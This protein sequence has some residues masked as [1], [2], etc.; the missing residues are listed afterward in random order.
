MSQ[1]R[2]LATRRFL[3]LFATQALGAFNDN[4]FRNALA[5]LITYDLAAG[6]GIDATLVITLAAGLFIVPF[7]LFS[8]IAGALADKYDKA[9]LSRRFKL[10]EIVLMVLAAIGFTIESITWQL[11]VLFLMGTQSAFFGPI[12]YGILPQHL[13]RR[14]LVGA[15]ALVEMGTFLAILTGLMFGGLM[16]QLAWG[17][18]IVSASVIAIAALGYLAARA[19]PAAPPAAPGLKIPYSIIPATWRLVR[20][21]A[22]KPPTLKAIVAI[23]WFW[24][25][26]AIFLAQLP[27]FTRFIVG[28]DETVTNLFIACF[29]IGIAAGSL[30]CNRILKGT[31]SARYAPLAAFAITVFAV[32]LVFAARGMQSAGASGDALMGLRDFLAVPAHWRLIGD[33]VGIAM[34]GGVFVV[35]LYA[36]I[37]ALSAPEQRARVIASNNVINALFMT[38]ATAVGSLFIAIG[39]DVADIFLSF[40]AFN[41]VIAAGSLTLVRFTVSADG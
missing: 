30:L 26:G 16:I 5:I 8:A 17:P 24:A 35:P 6:Q 20:E 34:S 11:V 13:D 25:I 18:Q 36:I 33:L 1:F 10:I 12:K 4:A 31:I 29:T 32:D 14:D 21:A 15:N 28:A 39:L 37:Q 22:A 40:A 7:F 41:L 3:P 27:A 2:L 38:L 19:I 23:S 9:T